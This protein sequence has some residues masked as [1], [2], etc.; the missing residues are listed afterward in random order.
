V[1]EIEVISFELFKLKVEVLEPG[2]LSNTPNIV[3]PELIQRFKSLVEFNLGI[4]H[5]IRIICTENLKTLVQNNQIEIPQPNEHALFHFDLPILGVKLSISRLVLIKRLKALIV[6]QVLQQMHMIIQPIKVEKLILGLGQRTGC[7][8]TNAANVANV[9]IQVAGVGSE[10]FEHVKFTLKQ[11]A[12]EILLLQELIETHAP[13]EAQLKLVEL[14][15]LI[16]RAE[17]EAVDHKIA[18]LRKVVQIELLDL[19]EHVVLAQRNLVQAVDS[20]HRR[21]ITTQA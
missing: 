16:K 11:N 5:F 14:N 10:R 2:A 3:L 19:I 20:A 18:D 8:R 1:H 9:L 15:K 7:N 4:R 17:L 12:S 6:V 13:A 21:R